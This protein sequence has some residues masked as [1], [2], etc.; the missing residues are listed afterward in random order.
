M[1]LVSTFLPLY[2]STGVFR[3]VQENTLIQHDGWLLIAAAIAVA[4]GGFAARNGT[5]WQAVLGTAAVSAG[6]LAL[7]AMDKS[8]RTL[9]PV[10]PSGAIDQNAAG[11]VVDFDIAIYVAFA[12]MALAA[13][14]AL[15]LRKLP[16]DGPA[17]GRK[18]CPDCAESVQPDALV[19]KHCGYRFQPVAAAAQS[20]RIAAASPTS[21]IA[22]PTSLPM[23]PPEGRAVRCHAC[24]AVQRVPESSAGQVVKCTT[25]QAGMRIK[26]QA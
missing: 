9:Y 12:G 16:E 25:C 8:N 24:Q 18:K 20:P 23:N 19:C 14:G 26:P 3:T 6:G 2:E 13:V 22:P 17:S 7:F 5:G 11:S 10:G 15:M 4:A 21:P 1:M